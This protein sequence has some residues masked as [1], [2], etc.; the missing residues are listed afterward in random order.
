[1]NLQKLKEKI[2]EKRMSVIALSNAISIDKSTLYR[3]LD[4]DSK[5]SIDEAKNIANILELS[6]KELH[7]IFF[8]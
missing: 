2:S 7:E 4:G 6:S 8:D 1:M 3:K 5:F